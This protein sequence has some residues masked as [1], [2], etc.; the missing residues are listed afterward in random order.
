MGRGRRAGEAVGLK[1]RPP[2]ETSVGRWWVKIAEVAAAVKGPPGNAGSVGGD[3]ERWP[4]GRGLQFTYATA[5][6]VFGGP[7]RDPALNA[8]GVGKKAPLFGAVEAEGRGDEGSKG[9]CHHRVLLHGVSASV[10]RRGL[11]STKWT[12]GHK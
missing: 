6:A 7:R 3:R 11:A 9:Q 2:G 10:S 1:R 8:V 12:A 4:V 5:P